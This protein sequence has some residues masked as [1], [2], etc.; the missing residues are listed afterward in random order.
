LKFSGVTGFWKTGGI[1]KQDRPTV[2]PDGAIRLLPGAFLIIIAGFVLGNLFSFVS[3]RREQALNREISENTV[4]SIEDV[5][6]IVHDIDMVRILINAHIFEKSPQQML[7][8]EKRIAQVQANLSGVAQEYEPLTTSPGERETWEE[9]WDD[10]SELQQPVA[11]VLALSRDN[12]D[13][14]ARQA[15]V[16]IERRFE[17]INLKAEQLLKLNRDEARNSVSEIH[18]LQ[19]GALLFFAVTT[20]F[21]TLLAALV[22]VWVIRLLRRR[23]RQIAEGAALLEE[24]NQELDAFAGRVAHDLRGPLSA[25]R[26]S[27]QVPTNDGALA[28]L[29]RGVARM[30]ALIRDLLTLSR[31]GAE[32]TATVTYTGVIVSS[33]K[34][35]LTP[36]VNSVNGVL[37]I[38]LEP[39]DVRCSEVLLRQV[40]WNIGENA[41]KYRR[42][43]VPLEV[44]IEGRKVGISYEFRMSDNGTGMSAEDVAHVFDPFFRASAAR[45][46]PGTGLGLSIVKRVI[47][48]SGGSVSLTSQLARGTTFV[49]ALPLENEASMWDRDRKRAV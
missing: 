29:K 28:V 1:V 40:L 36:K 35:E 15:M 39:A 14:E 32:A 43:D 26:L 41:V 33:L 7:P 25:L 17:S 9:L 21:A 12:R 6:R 47:E 2:R 38:D 48:A 16:P 22:A 37:R 49:I 31:A 20:A 24:R 5:S 27:E 11:Q 30:D 19:S 34:E 23:D 42:P 13:E 3:G 45:S 44:G 46:T 18:T 10:I 4:V 8:L